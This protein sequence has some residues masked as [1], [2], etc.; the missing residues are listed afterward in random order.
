[1][2]VR[3]SNIFQSPTFHRFKPKHKN[4]NLHFGLNPKENPPND[5]FLLLLDITNV[6]HYPFGI[7]IITGS[8][9]VS[10]IL[11]N[12]VISAASKSDGHQHQNINRFFHSFDW[13]SP[14]Q[15]L[16]ALSP[17]SLMLTVFSH[18]L[19]LAPFST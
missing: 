16:T 19:P 11:L 3:C 4:V 10:A 15:I 5:G 2:A 13:L 12:M 14:L 8:S 18:S 17:V 1:M 9:A 7:F 6:D